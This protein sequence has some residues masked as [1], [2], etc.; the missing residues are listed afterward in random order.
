MQDK[1]EFCVN[2]HFYHMIEDN[3]EL[4]KAISNW[5]NPRSL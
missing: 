5:S 1:I 3:M 2:H 4:L